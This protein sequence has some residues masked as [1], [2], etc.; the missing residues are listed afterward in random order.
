MYETNKTKTKRTDKQTKRKTFYENVN[1]R[2][3]FVV[4]VVVITPLHT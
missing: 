4:A 1:V 3:Y 2:W